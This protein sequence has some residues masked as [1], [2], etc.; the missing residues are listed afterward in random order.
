M[1]YSREQWGKVTPTGAMYC[2]FLSCCVFSLVLLGPVERTRVTQ[3]S[4]L[5]ST[6]ASRMF[7]VG[8]LLFGTQTTGLGSR[9]CLR[10][11]VSMQKQNTVNRSI[12]CFAEPKTSTAHRA[13]L[14]NADW[15]PL[16]EVNPQTS[17]SSIHVNENHVCSHV[18]AN[19]SSASSEPPRLK[20]G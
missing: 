5:M 19:L 12:N 3:S 17:R 1:F 16:G 8:R 14:S 13:V 6:M 9:V 10:G 2:Q 11:T 7:C 15:Q 18:T 20:A 4:E